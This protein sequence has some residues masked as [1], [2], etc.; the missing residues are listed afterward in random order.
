MNFTWIWEPKTSLKR[1]ICVAIL[2]IFEKMYCIMNHQTTH[3]ILV[4]RPASFGYNEQTALSNAFQNRLTIE[5]GKI[6]QLVLEEFD[7][8]VDKLRAHGIRVTVIDDD[9]S[10]N[11]PDAVFPNNWISLHADGTVVLYPMCTP[12]RRTER[13]MDIV[14]KL[15]QDH[16]VRRIIDLS[17]NE[18]ENRFLEGTGS[19]IFDHVN[20]LSYACLSKRTDKDL[21]I[22]T[23]RLL[24][25]DPLYFNAVDENGTP[26]YH[27]NVLMCLAEQFVVICLEAVQDFKEKKMIIASFNNAGQE[28]IDIS[29]S[30]MSCFS[31]NMLALKS[32]SGKNLL[33]ASQ[34]AYDS[35]TPY[36]LK[37]IEKYCFIISLP[38]S[39][40]E[41]IG[42]GSAR[43]I[44]AENFLP[45]LEKAAHV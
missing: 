22:K 28:I 40:I 9:S 13:R 30:Q 11:N 1:I 45:V 3:S 16:D 38:I 29:F 14:E 26:V 39:I 35:L 4:V 37:R 15:K 41:T 10:A 12:N 6:N 44:I 24:G 43:C 8:F 25:Y 42:G 33:A 32:A 5:V 34:S 7:A 17:Y 23:S 36:Q 20:K 27:T 21:F 19:I 2:I 31:G 18:G